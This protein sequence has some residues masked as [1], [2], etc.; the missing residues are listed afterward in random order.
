MQKTIAEV[1]SSLLEYH[2]V[3][4]FILNKTIFLNKIKENKNLRKNLLNF[5]S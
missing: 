4:S 1:K 2:Y 5:E 3:L